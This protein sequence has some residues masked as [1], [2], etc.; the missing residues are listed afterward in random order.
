MTD[1][2]PLE[3]QVEKSGPVTRVVTVE[4]PQ[5]RY[6]EARGS[7][8]SEIGRQAR[9]PGFR[10]GKAP[11]EVIEQAYAS[12]V[13]QA[14]HERLIRDSI[15]EALDQVEDRVLNVRNVEPSPIESGD[16]PFRYAATVEVPPPVKLKSYKKLKAKRP[17]AEIDE[18]D[19]RKVLDDLRERNAE[20]REASDDEALAEG[21]EVVLSYR[22]TE[23]G[24]PVPD[25]S[26][27]QYRTRL[28]GSG[29]H[30]E[31][32]KELFGATGGE[33]RS[34]EITFTEENAPSEE[35]AGRTIHFDVDV[36]E[37][38]KREL[39]EV[40]DDFAAKML[41]GASLEELKDR[42]RKDIEA[43]RRH[44]ADRAVE[45]QL[46]DGLL[47]KHEFDVPTGVV[48]RRRQQ[49]AEQAAHN[50]L[51]QGYPQ[52]TI[53]QMAPMLLA[54]VADRAEKE[55]RL[56]F[57]LEEIAEAEE[58]EVSDEEVEAELLDAARQQGEQG[59]AFVQRAKEEGFYESMR[60]ELRNRKALAS[61]REHANIKDVDPEKF[62]EEQRK[63]AEQAQKAAG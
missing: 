29:L 35:L 7:V 36:E 21:D 23:D 22:A 5:Q 58:V 44:E 63:A 1:A 55:V 57:L 48:E 47:E 10:P 9:V 31:F 61:V 50:L 11:P 49:L 51:H 41:D 4:I 27:E 19:V 26:A 2:S 34:F 16:G 39:P 38:H 14:L 43:A 17:Y 52:E 54:E 6:E 25:G 15:D 46:I 32:E 30:P 18:A 8:L 28:D 12:D 40:D 13:R 37:V 53:Q 59:P 45:S 60:S 62:A 56:G 3:V 20:Y 24:E 42:I 33:H